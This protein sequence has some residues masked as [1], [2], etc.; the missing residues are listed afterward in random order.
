[1]FLSRIL[2]FAL[3]H[4]F[5]SH[6]GSPITGDLGDI[7]LAM[8]C[9]KGA[10]CDCAKSTSSCDIS[11]NVI[12]A[13]NGYLGA[14][15]LLESRSRELKAFSDLLQSDQRDI[16]A[17]KRRN[18][19]Q[20]SQ[21]P[22]IGKTTMLGLLAKEFSRLLAESQE[23]GQVTDQGSIG[24]LVTYNGAITSQVLS[25]IDMQSA[26]SLRILYGALAC[27]ST[28]KGKKCENLLSFDETAKSSLKAYLTCRI[29]VPSTLAALWGWFGRRPIFVGIDE[30]LMC[31][32][33]IESDKLES[34]MTAAGA[35]LDTSIDAERVSVVVSAFSPE[36]FMNATIASSREIKN[37]VVLPLEKKYSVDI[38]RK[39][40][41]NL[42]PGVNVPET[43][44][45][46]LEE[47]T[48]GHAR[49]VGEVVDYIRDEISISNQLSTSAN[50]R[51]IFFPLAAYLETARAKLGSCTKPD[52][53]EYL[54]SRPPIMFGEKEFQ[55]GENN[56]VSL[57]ELIYTGQVLIA[58]VS[59]V[60]ITVAPWHFLSLLKKLAMTYFPS[61]LLL[62]QA[63]KLSF[64]PNHDSSWFEGFCIYFI[65]D[66][67]R[68]GGETLK[69]VVP[70]LDADCGNPDS[71][72]IE[73]AAG[74]SESW[75]AKFNKPLEGKFT[76][77]ER[78]LAQANMVMDRVKE[79]KCACAAARSK[80]V[81]L[82]MPPIFTA[83]HAI[84]ITQDKV[85]GI[86]IKSKIDDAK[87]MKK[88]SNVRLWLEK[89]QDAGCDLLGQE[90]QVMYM[91]GVQT[92]P[93]GLKLLPNEKI[94]TSGQLR[95]HFLDVFFR[96]GLTG[97]E[98]NS[99][100]E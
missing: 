97:G 67:I 14:A 26:L 62:Q 45:L 35:F 69:A 5:S 29:D 88:V 32:D 70:H 54:I 16:Q 76:D 12:G 15:A 41:G 90:G 21:C 68:R 79:L 17:L 56:L 51:D 38:L 36:R 44:L 30:A 40:L 75:L 13:T 43:V 47:L 73:D 60:K 65:A 24:C 77:D 94:V 11:L 86:Q 63:C 81:I 1:M 83:L 80:C 7:S 39:L 72:S 2:C 95:A 99:G 74:G 71:I 42:S 18:L 37:I 100:E 55:L 6:H 58:S 84:L 57:D 49:A 66:A 46:Q 4:H 48:G 78:K 8:M 22:G 64:D 93:A 61:T 82:V 92:A 91:V 31:K 19:I 3:S 50:A 96:F 27:H 85:V 10:D 25:G 89:W 9:R 59:P 87:F 28:R 23:S 34:L 20:V 52:V 53:L 98:S 33:G